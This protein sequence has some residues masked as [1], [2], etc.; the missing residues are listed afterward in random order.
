MVRVPCDGV[1][2]HLRCVPVS[3]PITAEAPALSVTLKWLTEDK[4]VTAMYMSKE[5]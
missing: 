1:V 3:P 2:T 5:M 4:W